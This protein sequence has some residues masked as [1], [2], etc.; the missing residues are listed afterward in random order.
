MQQENLSMEAILP[1]GFTMRPPT[2]DDTQSI[3]DCINA[4]LQ[5]VVGR[6]SF[7]AEKVK[8][9]L[10][11]P[12]I[13]MGRDTRI[14]L[15]AQENVVAYCGLW[16][17]PPHVETD[18]VIR[19]HPDYDK[20]YPFREIL[21]NWGEEMAKANIKRAPDDAQVDVSCWSLNNDKTSIEYLQAHGYVQTRSFYRMGIDL[22]QDIPKPQ[23]PDNIRIITMAELQDLPKVY[24]A[25]DEAF[26]DHWGYVSPPEAEGI[27]DFE[28]WIATSP[29]MDLN[30]WYLAM[31]GDEIAA[32]SLC[33]PY[34]I[35][36]EHIG[37][38]DTL[39]VRANWRRQG[40]ALALLHYSFRILKDIGRRQ[41]TL[42]VDASSLTGATRLYEKAGMSVIEHSMVLEKCLRKGTDYRTQEL[43]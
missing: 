29:N 11:D 26:Q 1:A 37:Y 16:N 40:I 17:S 20:D 4:Y 31:D 21:M 15:N 13:D 22:D 32:M 39:G 12:S 43:S 30:Y 42:D 10:T 38:V 27:K 18:I 34:L 23:F 36:Q 5:A 25:V 7:S 24:R 19:I 3:S 28:H 2:L 41:V 33:L 6:M 8:G 9:I 35:G 14:M